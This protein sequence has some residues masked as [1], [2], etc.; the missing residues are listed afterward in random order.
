MFIA[1]FILCCLIFIFSKTEKNVLLDPL[2]L[3][4][5]GMVYY[6]FMIPAFMAFTGDYYIDFQ[7]SEISLSIAEFEELS[8]ALGSGYAAFVVGYRLITPRHYIDDAL[9]RARKLQNQE[10]YSEERVTILVASFS[11][12]ICISF[13]S[14]ELAAVLTSYASKIETRYD[15]SAFSFLYNFSILSLAGLMAFRVIFRPHPLRNSLIFATLMFVWSF[16]TF[17]KEPMVLGGLILLAGA[18]RLFPNRQNSILIA[19]LFVMG[20]VLLFLIPAFSF[21]R[22][23]GVVTFVDVRLYPVSFV[24]SDANGPF[25][26][27]VLA[28][29]QGS[30]INLNSLVESFALWVP[31]AIWSERPLDAAET[32][33]QAVMADWR[34]GYGL[35]FSPFAE[36]ILRFGWLSPILL[37]IAGATA[38]SLQRAIASLAMP[39]L[40]PSFLLINQGY[41]LFTFHR[42]AFS[43]LITTTLQFWAPLLVLTFTLHKFLNW[44]SAKGKLTRRVFIEKY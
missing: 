37:F 12:L 3:Y 20:L 10:I 38:S 15:A 18:S 8:Y 6:G 9:N 33:A 25:S 34:P 40:V 23:T 42:G 32:F 7:G 16:L 36:G 21:Y 11:A 44:H 41:I 35:G 26:T 30:S 4:F 2:T 27:I 28:V 39:S 31:R 24:F 22:A 19:V 29:K 13:F 43:G 17:S 1:V 14:N 5:I